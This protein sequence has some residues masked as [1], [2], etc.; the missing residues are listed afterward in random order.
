MAPHSG[1][2]LV[3]DDEPVNLKVLTGYLEHAAYD[4][5]MAENGLEALG[6]LEQTEKEADG[7]FDLVLLDVMMPKMNG[8]EVCRKMRR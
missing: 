8:Y 4:V 6:Y 1:R 7:S 3:V 2:L 5:V